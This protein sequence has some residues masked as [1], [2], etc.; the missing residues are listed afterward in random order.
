[1]AHICS[2]DTVFGIVGETFVF[3]VEIT[4]RREEIIWKKN[5]DKVAEW[6]RQNTVT[7]FNAL[8]NRSQLK[9]DGSLTIY[10]LKKDDAGAYEL[11]YWD[12]VK[13]HYLNFVLDVLDPPSE[14]K[15]NWNIKG[16]NL[17]LNC[18]SDFQKTL[19]YSW[20]LSNDPDIY[21][22]QEFSIPIKNVD[23][24]KKATCFVTFSQTEKTSEISL[25]EC[26]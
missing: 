10:K 24:T 7:Y 9:E 19:N 6:D 4:Q 16:D 21:H 20:K 13:D 2:E 1:V 12:S 18:I 5:K 11:H 15:I 14:P 8:H 26:I 25:I 23:A 22:G 17:V 3:P